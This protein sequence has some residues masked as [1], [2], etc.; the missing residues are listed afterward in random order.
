MQDQFYTL[1][2]VAEM[3]KISYMTVFRWVREE[4]IKA[5]KIG[6]QYRIKKNQ[7]EIFINKQ[8]NN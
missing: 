3:L 5:H 4:K 6:K 7:L 1:Q 2:E 8:N